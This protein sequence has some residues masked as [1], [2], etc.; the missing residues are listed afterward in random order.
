MKRIGVLTFHRSY[1]YGACLQAYATVAFLNEKGYSAELIDYTNAYE[2]RF[3]KHFYTENGRPS[4]YITSFVKDV[5]L[6]KR[7]YFELA[8]DKP[9]ES[10]PISTVR[11]TSHEELSKANY[12]VMIVGSD[13][14][15]NR[16]IC[17]GLD[18]AFLLCYGNAEQRISVASS[19]GSVQ[20]TEDE[21][22]QFRKAFLRFSAIS[23]REVYAKNQLEP[24][25]DKSIKIL[26]DP[27]FL[28]SR[29]DWI[30]RLASRSKTYA[31]TKEKY[32]LTFFLAADGSYKEIVAG[33]ARRLSLPVWSIQSTRIKRVDCDRVILGATIED[34]VA[35]I[36]N[37]QLVITDSFHGSAMSINLKKNFVPIRNIGNPMRVVSLLEM[38]DLS[39]RMNMEAADYKEIDYET[40][41]RLLGPLREDSRNWIIDAIGD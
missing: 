39:T 4:G 22:E 19:M 23:T 25:T 17:N 8:F 9:N 12:D 14:V 32:I 34:F 11:Y 29:E 10:Y 13:Q 36:A 2:Q 33:Y 18:E 3:R 27:T 1:S 5:F 31:M 37:A 20:L 30:Q 26:M 28:F 40:V 24:L 41:E 35:L 38:L 15:W 16:N 7:H 21:K 6:R